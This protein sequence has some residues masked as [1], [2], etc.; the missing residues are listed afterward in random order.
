MLITKLDQL[1][2]IIEIQTH[3]LINLIDIR[4]VL[5]IHRSI[6]VPINNLKHDGVSKP[7]Q[8]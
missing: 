5:A 7:E 1:I 2:Q 8:S 4:K 6:S 3:L